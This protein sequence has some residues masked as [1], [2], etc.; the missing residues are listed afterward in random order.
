[1]IE[2][3][4]LLYFSITETTFGTLFEIIILIVY[5]GS[6]MNPIKDFMNT[7]EEFSI[8]LTLKPLGERS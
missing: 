5:V 1:M 3:L 6:R 2:L 8:K 7:M 4:K